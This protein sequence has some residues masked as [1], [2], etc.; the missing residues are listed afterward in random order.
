M[1]LYKLLLSFEFSQ[2]PTETHKYDNIYI[3]RVDI[4]LEQSSIVPVSL[5]IT[6]PHP[7]RQKS[8]FKGLPNKFFHHQLEKVDVNE[9]S[10]PPGFLSDLMHGKQ[11]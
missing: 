5:S 2:N 1:H 8:Y 9:F 7:Q 6:H 10:K 11:Y 4:R 3:C